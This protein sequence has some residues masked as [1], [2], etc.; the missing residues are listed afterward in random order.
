MKKSDIDWRMYED[1]H[2]VKYA[3]T[4]D[5][6]SDYKKNKISWQAYEVQY[7]KLIS[8]RKVENLSLIHI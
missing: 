4:K 8:E 2:N 5:I 1:F 7:E 3:P 6:L